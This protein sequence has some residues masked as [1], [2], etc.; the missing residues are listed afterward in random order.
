MK[1]GELQSGGYGFYYKGGQPSQAVQQ[2]DVLE[3]LQAVITPLAIRP[4]SQEPHARTR[5]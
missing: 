3:D 5:S 4:R 2:R 1:P